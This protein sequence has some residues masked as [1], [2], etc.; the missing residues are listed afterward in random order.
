[1]Y[2]YFIEAQEAENEAA[3][4]AASLAQNTG[5]TDFVAHAADVITRRLKGQPLKYR[6][7]GMY[8]PALKKLLNDHG[9]D[10][11]EDLIDDEV[12]KIYTYDKP[13]A[14]IAA[15]EGFKDFYR[16]TWAVGTNAFIIDDEGKNWTLFDD[17]ME[18]RS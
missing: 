18:T 13:A 2:R 7:F 15:A 6:E 12:G 4:L 8:W 17:D 10:L 5:E 1:M 9:A 14:L 11:G 16:E 3:A